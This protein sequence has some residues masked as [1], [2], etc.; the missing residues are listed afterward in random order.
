VSA[1]LNAVVARIAKQASP[2]A[3]VGKPIASPSNDES[4]SART[5]PPPARR[6]SES[7]E[8][9]NSARRLMLMSDSARASQAVAVRERVVQPASSRAVSWSIS[10]F[11]DREASTVMLHKHIASSKEKLYE[12]RHA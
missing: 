10:P 6:S 9:N 8:S 2:L 4:S 1:L 11:K 7:S 5:T 12:T 3:P